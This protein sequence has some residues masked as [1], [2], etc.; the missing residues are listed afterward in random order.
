MIV[1]GIISILLAIAVP[2]LLRTRISANE[3]IARKAIQTLRDAEYEYFE[4][5]LDDDGR[6]DF[7]NKLALYQEALVP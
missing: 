5:D 6:R 2:N 1:A 4:Q 7:K 3:T